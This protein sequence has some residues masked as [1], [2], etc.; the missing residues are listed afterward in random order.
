[1]YIYRM[2]HPDAKRV[3]GRPAGTERR[4]SVLLPLPLP[5]AL[6]YGIPDEVAA[7]PGDFVVVPLAR[8]IG[9]KA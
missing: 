3:D 1:M 2:Q 7:G 4:C 6:D 5:G 9:V 8:A